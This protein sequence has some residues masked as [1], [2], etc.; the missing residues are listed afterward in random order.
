MG[1]ITNYISV[2]PIPD[3]GPFTAEITA[4]QGSTPLAIARMLDQIPGNRAGAYNNSIPNLQAKLNATFLLL[5]RFCYRWLAGRR[6]FL[7]LTRTQVNYNSGPRLLVETILVVRVPR[8][9]TVTAGRPTYSVNA[10]GLAEMRRAIGFGPQR[11]RSIQMQS[12]LIELLDPSLREAMSNS[13]PPA[14]TP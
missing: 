4:D 7:Q 14:P 5:H 6:F 11:Q 10:A 9:R 13:P 12:E 3:M 1:Y 2:H 8:E